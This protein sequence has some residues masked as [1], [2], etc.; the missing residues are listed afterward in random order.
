VLVVLSSGEISTSYLSPSCDNGAKEM[1]G[2]AW[3]NRSMFDMLYDI[4]L[5]CRAP[6]PK[7]YIM[8][9][10]NLSYAQAVKYISMLTR[11]GL[12]ASYNGEYHSTE[13]AK[14]YIEAY[15]ELLSIA[16]PAHAYRP[17]TV[18]GSSP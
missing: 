2:G 6:R 3:R 1:E 10:A 12:L 17:V 5:L 7:T 18:F 11:N 13:R 8:Y 4:L 15:R 14:T 16:E 9:H